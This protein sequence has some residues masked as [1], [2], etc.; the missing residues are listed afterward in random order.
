M[1]LDVGIVNIEYMNTPKEP[2]S[3]FLADLA[4]EDLSEGWSGG[5]E[6]NAF[7]QIFKEDLER[8]A[9]DY[10]SEQGLSQDDAEK[11][12][13]WVRSIPWKRH[14]IMLYLNW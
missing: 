3:G 10:A 5:W 13:A 12:T 6:G 1:G 4:V 2:V 14:D 9:G 11:L 7:L 8:K